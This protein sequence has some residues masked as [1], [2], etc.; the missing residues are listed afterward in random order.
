MNDTD[1][2]WK[3]L[4][5]NTYLIGNCTTNHRDNG[6]FIKGCTPVESTIIEIIKEKVNDEK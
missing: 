6:I 4:Y 2:F 5:E 1:F 3:D